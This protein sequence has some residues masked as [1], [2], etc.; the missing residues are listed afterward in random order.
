LS[1]ICRLG[2]FVAIILRR[3][4]QAVQAVDQVNRDLAN[5]LA[6]REAELIASHEALR[7]AQQREVVAAERQ[8]LMQ[9][10]HDGM[11]S[12][13][14][15]AMRV[16]EAGALSSADMKAVLRDCLDDLR[17]TVD[18][19]EPVDADVL[20]LLAT[21][22]YRMAPRLEAAGLTIHWDIGGLDQLGGV[23]TLTWLD[24]RGALHILRILQ[25]ALSNILQHAHARSLRVAVVVEHDSDRPGVSVMLDD[26]GTGFQGKQLSALGAGK[27][28]GNMERRAQA[29]HARLSW[30]P[31]EPGTRFR[32]WLPLA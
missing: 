9:D 26:D 2:V 23:P 25:E 11:G 24:P 4:V 27:G 1:T 13:L 29:L 22:R 19:L 14:M 20:L 5:R 15:S 12:Q 3:H 31:L 6:V 21:L 7:D 28:L 16:A 30:L 18:S 10:L 8:R 32:L 17:L